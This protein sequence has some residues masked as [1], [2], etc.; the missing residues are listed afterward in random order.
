MIEGLHGFLALDADPSRSRAFVRAI[1]LSW[2]VP[3][4]SK[5]LG[6]GRATE[7]LADDRISSPRAG[8]G[9]TSTQTPT[10]L[11]G[12]TLATLALVA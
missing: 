2:Q 4:K 3:S 1:Q 9:M 8:R 12:Q 5:T 11:W 7:L 10:R 6:N